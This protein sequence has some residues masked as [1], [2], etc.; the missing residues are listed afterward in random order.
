V[1]ALVHLVA[2][3]VADLGCRGWNAHHEAGGSPLA[4]RCGGCAHRR[5]GRQTVIHE[6]HRPAPHIGRRSVATVGPLAAFQLR[7][8]FDG[9]R[10]D[11][12]SRNIQRVDHVPIQHAAATRSNGTHGQLFVARHPQFAH[13]E[14]IERRA[15]LM[16][17]LEPDRDAAPRQRQDEQ[18]PT[19]PV[20]VQFLRQ[21]AAGINPVTRVHGFSSTSVRRIWPLASVA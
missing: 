13:Q 11:H 12:I 21:L 4:E 1:I 16:G 8:L 2:E 10:L 9:D 14:H 18:G 17:H 7:P 6:D 15:E 19:A 20:V 3:V 5:A